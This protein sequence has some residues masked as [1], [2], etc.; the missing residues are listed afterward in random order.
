MVVFW[1]GLLIVAPMM[2][3]IFLFKTFCEAR[4]LENEERQAHSKMAAEWA[5]SFG[6]V[7]VLIIVVLALVSEIHTVVAFNIGDECKPFE[8]VMNSKRMLSVAGIGFAADTT[9]FNP[10][11]SIQMGLATLIGVV[12]MRMVCWRCVAMLRVSDKAT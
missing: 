3:F 4:R 12:L 10:V 9:C 1:I 11:A 5:H 7:D 2:E 6:C 8:S